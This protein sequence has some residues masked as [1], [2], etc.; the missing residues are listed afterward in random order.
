MLSEMQFAEY[1]NFC[2]QFMELFIYSYHNGAYFDSY[3]EIIDEY[4]SNWEDS[5]ELRQKFE[6]W[7]HE[8]APAKQIDCSFMDGGLSIYE[9][10]FSRSRDTIN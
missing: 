9:R 8:V 10:V 6:A 4:G 7:L 2:K 3:G 1:D 5:K